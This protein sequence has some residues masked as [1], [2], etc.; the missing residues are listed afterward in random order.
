MHNEVAPLIRIIEEKLGW[1]PASTW[2]SDDFD[3]LQ[4]AI[5]EKT[6]VSLS[7]STLRRLWGRAAYMN[8]PSAATLN[9]IARF[10]GFENWREYLKLQTIKDSPPLKRNRPVGRKRLLKPLIWITAAILVVTVLGGIVI[11]QSSEKSNS[12]DYTFS[13]KVLAKGVP[14]SVVFTY[15]ATSASSDSIYIQQS[16]DNR[17]R[18]SVEKRLHTHT[19]IYYEPGFFKAKLLAGN[20]IVKEHALLIPTEGWLGSIDQQP[21]PIYLQPADFLSDTMLHLSPATITR[22]N[23]ALEPLPP[24]VKFYQVG[25]F[26][27]VATHNFSF[28]AT[29]RNDLAT[30]AG[31]CQLTSIVLMTDDNP[32]II[33]LSAKGCTSELNLLSG[34]VMISGKKNDLSCFGVDLK[35]WV[36]VSCKGVDNK[37]QYFVNDQF[38]YDSPLPYRSIHIVGMAYVFHGSGAVKDVL[39][40]DG[41]KTVFEAF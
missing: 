40:E 29:V 41:N 24:V 15:D 2:K 6:G 16:W 19:S 10:A 38:V 31:A 32:I 4:Q 22:K 7:I 13:S 23:I 27:P 3:A 8:L 21:V 14:N 30:G 12:V 34:D 1:G 33:P 39:L 9:C 20:Q 11:K 5:F 17:R 35:E 25:A 36:K 37:L 28:S 26:A 18:E